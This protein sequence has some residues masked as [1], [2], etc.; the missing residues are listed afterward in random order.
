VLVF[1]AGGD[2]VA[3]VEHPAEQTVSD[4]ASSL[5]QGDAETGEIALGRSPL[6]GLGRS[7]GEVR[8]VRRMADHLSPRAALG[9]PGG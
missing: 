1:R 8:D 7:A 3:A 9:E 6:T 5:V 4:Q 2:A